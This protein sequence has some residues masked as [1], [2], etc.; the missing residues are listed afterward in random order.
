MLVA[1]SL[2]TACPDNPNNGTP[3][4]TNNRP[5]ECVVTDDEPDGDGDGAPDTCD[6]CPDTA[7]EGQSDLDHDGVGDACDD[8]D[9]GDGVDDGEDSCPD[10]FQGNPDLDS[11]GDGIGDQCDPCPAGT[12]ANDTD[13]D[14][15]DDCADLCG[16]LAEANNDDADDDHVGDACDNCP[17]VP[18][19]G[20]ID[21]DGDGVGDACD[22]DVAFTVVEADLA[23]VQAAIRADEV[24]CAE[25]ADAY[26]ARIAQYELDV[27]DGPPIN[28]FVQ[29]NENVREQAAALDDEYART[30]ELVGPLHCAVFG[31]KTNHGTTDTDSTNGMLALFGTRNKKDSWPV[32]MLRERGAILIGATAMDEWARGIFAIGSAHGRTGN[33]FDPRRNPGGSSSGSGAMVGASFAIGGTGTDNCASLTVPAAYNGLVTMRSTIGLV[34]T[35]GLFPSGKADTVSGPMARTV[36]DMTAML[37]AMAT[38][39][40]SDDDQRLSAWSRP[41]SFLDALREDG[42]E[43]K[44]V[45]VV[46]RFSKENNGA[47]RHPFAGGGP[48]IHRIWQTAL[49]DMRRAGATVVENVTFPEFDDHRVGGGTVVPAIDDYLANETTGFQSFDEICESGRFSEHVYPDTETCLSRIQSSRSR[50]GQA[51]SKLANARQHY[52]DNADY[53]TSVMDRLDLDVIVYP[54]DANGPAGI[55]SAKANCIASSVTGMPVA[56]VLAGFSS[57]TPALPVGLMIQGRKFDETAVIEAAYAYEQATRHR[58]GPE[59]TSAT[60]A[61]DVPTLDPSEYNDLHF[62]IAEKAWADVLRDNGKFDLTGSVFTQIVTD[63]LQERGTTYLLP[64]D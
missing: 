38:Y 20:Q 61:Q 22:D 42:L 35:S 43:G 13:G 40:P 57:D 32:A 8:D 48:D 21:T 18:N 36:R 9:D 15:I 46:R 47:Y 16:D 33:A 31:V 62:A 2:L 64:P 4:T 26:L 25:V 50:A 10:I 56:T 51:A 7:N 11:D 52:Q 29:L 17:D 14:G 53:L 55:T 23:Q 49:A 45:G 58:R 39:N 5:Q 37:D 44:R 60:A 59:L 28:A 34:S 3:P 30:G 63:I 27:S 41:N 54:V 12:D 19:A 6:N 1:V 24:T